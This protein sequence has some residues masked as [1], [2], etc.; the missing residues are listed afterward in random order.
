MSV[1]GV[2]GT[3]LILL[4]LM[5]FVTVFAALAGRIKLPYPIV[6]VIAG[7]LLGFVPGIP[8]INLDPEIIFLVILPPLLYSAAS[9][10][11]WRDFSHN[12][13]SISMLALGL[14]GFTV[15]AV[16]G[17]GPWLFSGFDWRIGFVLG[18][19][20]ATTDAIAATSIA[21]S[22][23][24]P[25]T[26]VDLLEGESL[27]NDA[28]GLLAL[29]FAT[30]LVVEGR[31]PTVTAGLLRLIYLI[32]GGIGVGLLIG[33]IVEW[34]E[35]RIDD[36]P[37]E[38]GLSILVPYAAHLTAESIHSSGVLAVVAA[39]LYLGRRSSVFFSP[40]VRLQSRA[41]WNA[42]EFILNGFVFVLIGL[43]LPSVLAGVSELSLQKLILYAALFS[44]FIILL[45]LLWT[46]PG[47]YVAHFI[48]RRFLGQNEH[49]PDA[50]GIFVVGWAGM[51]GVLS[52]AAAISL[53]QIIANGKPFPHRDLI[54][55]L[56]FSVILVTLV[57]QGLTLPPLIRLLGLAGTAETNREEQDARRLVIEA[58]L[59]SLEE[60]RAADIRGSSDVYD[61][62]ERHYQHRLAS[63]ISPSFD[64]DHSETLHYRQYLDL[65]RALLNVER[66]TALRLRD[67]G[68]IMDELLREIEHELDLSETRLIASQRA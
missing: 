38:I 20:V 34:F 28:T 54:I 33:R 46:F 26:I 49:R 64:E 37:I 17:V 18:A 68:H 57:V 5:L 48:R 29:E 63:V 56:T 7:L 31:H 30:A 19:A 12:L 43:Q 40:G 42:L 15:L 62:L 2:H 39:G 1:I 65:S 41:V 51:R 55:F 4:L 32:T 6:L 66:R 8:Q 61:D 36:G 14:V 23:G 67:Q 60:M 44:V 22:I 50:R 16:A 25:K 3:Q 47:A 35:H 59:V 45:R 21:K 52:L 11:S 58:A 13:V 24:L 53:P 10:T 27:I 9:M